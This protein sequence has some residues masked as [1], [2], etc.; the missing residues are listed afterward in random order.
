MAAILTVRF[1]PEHFVISQ[2]Q[3]AER[4]GDKNGPIGF[5]GSEDAQR[6]TAPHAHRKQQKWA[7]ATN[8]SPECRQRACD[9]GAGILMW[10]HVDFSEFIVKMVL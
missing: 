5:Q 2:C 10:F 6:R 1:V 4:D 3:Q 9:Q 8:G 7:K